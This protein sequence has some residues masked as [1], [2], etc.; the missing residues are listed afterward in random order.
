MEQGKEVYAVPGRITDIL[1]KGC[2][3]LIAQGAMIA[4]SAQ[5]ILDDIRS[6]YKKNR[7]LDLSWEDRHFSGRNIEP[8]SAGTFSEEEKIIMEN[9]D[10]IVAI[11]FD[12]ILDKTG[13]PF[14]VLTYNLINLEMKDHI[15]Q[16]RQN[17]YLKKCEG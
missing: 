12:S 10:E 15:L 17:L 8:R 7:G 1:S 13:L 3:H 11:S 14:D 4:E 2:N 6:L 9:L 5:E 16:T